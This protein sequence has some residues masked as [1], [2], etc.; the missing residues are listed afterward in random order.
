MKRQERN[1]GALPQGGGG[2]APSL[3]ELRALRQ[4]QR[5]TNQRVEELKLKLFRITERHMDQTV[6]LIRRWMDDKNK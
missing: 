3:A 6:G 5:A 1:I 2:L 4:A